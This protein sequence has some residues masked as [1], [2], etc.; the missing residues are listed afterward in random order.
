MA[1]SSYYFVQIY[2]LSV[3]KYYRKVMLNEHVGIVQ[4]ER[5]TTSLRILGS[6]SYIIVRQRMVFGHAILHLAF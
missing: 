4:Y 5:L 1:K 2:N 6:A 3:S